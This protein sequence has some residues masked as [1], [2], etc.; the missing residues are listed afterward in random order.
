MT[1]IEMDAAR[2]QISAAQNLRRIADALEVLV[3]IL[4]L[5]PKNPDLDTLIS[6]PETKETL[7][8]LRA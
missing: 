6:L 4:T 3:K 1:N 5:T 7:R 8:S 2:A